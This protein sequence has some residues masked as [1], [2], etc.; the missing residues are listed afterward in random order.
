[1]SGLSTPQPLSHSKATPQTAHVAFLLLHEKQLQTLRLLS[2]YPGSDSS[3]CGP[4]PVY[5]RPTS[6][7]LSLLATF[8]G[9]CST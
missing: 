6:Y 4:S 8:A 3:G 2:D 5:P 9:R 7:C 1:M